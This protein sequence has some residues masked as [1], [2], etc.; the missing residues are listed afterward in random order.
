MHLTA[1]YSF[2]SCKKENLKKTVRIMKLTAVL[3]F[4]ACLHLAARSDGQTV[5]LSMKDKPLKEVFRE[6]QKQTGI[7][8]MVKESLLEKAGK[9]SVD[10]KNMPLAD[11]LN[12]CLKDSPLQYRIEAGAVV[13]EEKKEQPNER[14]TETANIDVRGKIVNE[15]G[16]PVVGSVFVKGT[17]K[18][19]ATNDNGEFVL[20]GIDPGAVLVISGVGFQSLEVRVDGH[21]DIG[22]IALRTRFGVE[23]TI[24]VDVNTGYQKIPKERA[25]GSFIVVDSALLNRT[26]G[27]D[28]LSRLDGIILPGLI[29]DKR[30]STT[31]NHNFLS[32]DGVST[33]TAAISQPLIVLDNFPY[34][35]DIDNINPNDIESVTILRDAAAGSIWGARAG[36]GVIVITTK[37]GKYNKPLQVSFNTNF[38]VSGKPDLF[39]LPH[40]S[41]SDFIDVEK[42]L[43]GKGFYNSSLTSTNY[44]F[45]SPVV[46]ILAKARAGTIGTAEANAQIDALRSVDARNDYSK[47][48]Y[49]KTINQQYFVNLSGGA[50]QFNYLLTAGFDKNRGSTVRL[51]N[52]RTSIRAVMGFRPVKN[53]EFQTELSYIEAVSHN[54]GNQSLL[55]YSPNVLPYLTLADENGNPLVVGKDY[56]IGFTDTAGG[57]KLL[58]W[59]YRPLAELDASSATSKNYNLLFNGGINYKL[60][61]VFSGSLKYQYG[62]ISTDQR[63]WQGQGSYSTRNLINEFT[64]IS[65]STVT[66]NLPLGGII[67]QANAYTT[68]YR[69]RAQINADKTWKG[70]HQLAAIA[71]AELSESHSTSNNF[72][73]YGYDDKLL[74]FQN[75]NSL[76]AYPQYI[77]NFSLQ[78]TLP[79]IIDFS[80]QL[81]RFTSIFANASYSY[82]NRYIVSA[83]ARKDA[84]NV[85]GVSTNQRGT[86]LWSA[87][88]S[89]DISKEPFYKV[90]FLSHLR[91][92][93]SY[94]YQGNTNSKLSGLSTL[95][96]DGN[97]TTSGLP[98]A[99]IL[100][101]DNPGLRWEKLRT[102]N[103]GLDFSLINSRISGSFDYYKKL[104]TDVLSVAPLDYTTGFGFSTV[105]NAEMTGKGIDMMIH[106]SNLPGKLKWNTDLVFS[107]NENKVTKYTPVFPPSGS[108]VITNGYS[109]TPI[110]GKPAY[111]IFSYK[112]AGLDNLTG[113]P[114]GYIN[115]VPSKNYSVLNAAPITDLQYNGS[116]VPVYFGSFR[117]E[118]SWKGISVSANIV[119][120][121]HYYFRRNGINYSKLIS[122]SGAVGHPDYERRWQKPGDELSTDVPSLVYP[123]VSSRNTFY[124]NSAAL[125]SKAD[126]IRLQ[127]ITFGYSINQPNGFFKTARIYGN[128]SN[129]GIL[130]RAN[131]YHLDPDYGNNIPF[132][133]TLAIGLNA[134]F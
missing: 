73:T 21:T 23:Q 32:L 68:S 67:N 99:N 75:V 14:S 82:K 80:D 94:G 131:R 132:P 49:Q 95:R 133:L 63:N 48:V 13:I 111:T 7:N 30:L 56:R 50:N 79:T 101:P 126:N 57:G 85:F 55:S 24:T 58:D 72:Q 109:I 26:T 119:Y 91:V 87:G 37:K 118:L 29:F 35:G 76:I 115:G 86:P 16:E 43:F 59:K 53:L 41:T 121:L 8:I 128:V 33:L 110:V 93:A 3:L 11:V 117:N 69:G 46:E 116:A 40:M 9:L 52:E 97:A 27:R 124:T 123:N 88:A 71:G 4:A 51:D 129:I 65:G 89:W 112:W 98:Y 130:W 19:T 113:D 102:T 96:Y 61:S 66:R 6:I 64:Q 105:N 120:K 2:C 114:M 78:N 100:N 74:T 90:K 47:Y 134:N 10:V 22:I 36:N 31:P 108:S 34:D 54:L 92:R 20:K 44:P 17:K 122:T 25:T 18:G 81:Y 84:S 15:K 39:Y 62:K 104:A 12:L 38:S 60:N 1:I 103:F 45:L 127:D 125:V 77:T 83:S 70:Q 107:Y 28:I 42:F 5:T 106:S